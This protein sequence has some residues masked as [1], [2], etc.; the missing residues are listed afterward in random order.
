MVTLL[1]AALAGLLPKE[2]LANA[3]K[4]YETPPVNPVTVIGDV[5]LDA[6]WPSEEATT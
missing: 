4:V 1:L 5:E 2:L 3:R 6:V